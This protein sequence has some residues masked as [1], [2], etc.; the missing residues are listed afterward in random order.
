MSRTRLLWIPHAP[1]HKLGGQRPQHLAQRLAERFEVHVV[2]WRQP[3]AP[4]VLGAY[5]RSGWSGTDVTV[6]E[7]TLAPNIYVLGGRRYPPQWVLGVNQAIFRRHVRRVL[8]GGC[9]VGIFAS[10]HHFTGYPP[11][12]PGFPWL[13]DYLDLSPAAVERAYCSAASGVLAASCALAERAARYGRPV[14]LL[15]NGVHPQPYRQADGGPVRAAIGA[16]P[17]VVI[18]LI[19]LTCSP[20]LYFVEALARVARQRPVLLL[21]VGDGPMRPAIAR[22]AQALGLPCATPG[23]VDPAHIPPYFAASDLGLY[24]G[25]DTPY[26]RAA[27]PLKVLEYLAAGRPVVSSPVDLWRQ[28]GLDGVTTAAPTAEA[29]ARAVTTVLAAPAATGA[30]PARLT[31][32]GLAARLGDRLADLVAAGHGRQHADPKEETP[33]ASW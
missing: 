20:R 1:W 6:H 3:K 27:A 23:W 33:C 18:S 31:W 16:G 21:A 25:D 5:R 14:W 15:P 9:D 13:F 10:S 29:F 17:A 7:V 26:F 4:C 32:D 11:L 2:S 12:A 22:R 28:L 30:V 19:G 8:A 24:P